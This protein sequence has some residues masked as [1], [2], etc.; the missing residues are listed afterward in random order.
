M[1][2]HGVSL[3]FVWSTLAD[4]PLQQNYPLANVMVHYCLKLYNVLIKTFCVSQVLVFK[5]FM[6][7]PQMSHPAK[8]K[9]MVHQMFSSGCPSPET[10]HAGKESC[11]TISLPWTLMPSQVKVQLFWCNLNNIKFQ[12]NS[13]LI[14]L[15]KLLYNYN[16]RFKNQINILTLNSLNFEAA[17]L[18]D[19]TGHYQMIIS[20]CNYHICDTSLS[21]S[22]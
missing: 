6:K 5:V 10:W 14:L 20:I 1:H 13:L 2:T 4:E 7:T 3:F 9:R 11:H 12:K 19:A 18:W 22:Q 17:P 21:S 8:L 16:E 15:N